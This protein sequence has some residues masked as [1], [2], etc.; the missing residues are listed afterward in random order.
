MSNPI[1]ETFT[2][3]Q[4]K[5]I[6]RFWS[7]LEIPFRKNKCI[8]KLET[9]YDERDEKNDWEEILYEAQ[10][11]QKIE[12]DKNFLES[13]ENTLTNKLQQEV[14][15]LRNDF[16]RKLCETEK[17]IYARIEK[18]ETKN[19]YHKNSIQSSSSLGNQ[20]HHVTCQYSM[21]FPRLRDYPTVWR[22]LTVFKRLSTDI[23]DKMQTAHLLTELAPKYPELLQEREELTWDVILEKIK[24]SDNEIKI[25]EERLRK[26]KWE[27]KESVEQYIDRLEAYA[28]QAFPGKSCEEIFERILEIFW[29]TCNR[30]SLKKEFFRINEKCNNVEEFLNTF[31]KAKK[32]DELE[33]TPSWGMAHVDAK[34]KEISQKNNSG[35]RG[36]SCLERENL[37]NANNSFKFNVQCYLCKSR[38]HLAEE[39][40]LAECYACHGKGHFARICPFK[41]ENSNARPTWGGGSSENNQPRKY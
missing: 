13:L 19:N 26:V 34:Q 24:N 41:S 18:L 2:T 27:P 22:Y 11:H 4:L 36:R 8:E 30:P 39:C 9:L 7:E 21:E 38:S 15:I 14:E 31:R 6:L 32:I 3:P 17:E 25:C 5:L 40:P 23:P 20:S 29:K 35:F 37:V 16:D 1:P 28:E 10:Q 33:E 12:E